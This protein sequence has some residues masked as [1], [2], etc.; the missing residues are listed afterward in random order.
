MAATH[1]QRVA[2]ARDVKATDALHYRLIFI[3]AYLVLFVPKVIG[4]VFAPRALYAPEAT[5]SKPLLVEVRE[6]A[7]CCAGIAM[8]G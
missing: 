3:A 4:R 8:Q 1:R 5:R 6:A 7:H 2:P